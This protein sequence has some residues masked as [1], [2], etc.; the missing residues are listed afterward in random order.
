MNL[1]DIIQALGVII[2]GFF[3]YNQYTKNKLTDLKVEQLKHI[4][5]VRSKKRLDNS[6]RTYEELWN[7]LYV[8]KCDRIY[9]IQPHPLGNEDMLSI[10]F[11]VKRRS[12]EG[13]K[14]E[15]QNKKISE[16]AKFAGLL[17]RENFMYITDIEKQVE[18]RYAQHIF[19]LLDSKNIVIKK[20][21]DNKYDW[22]GTIVC[23]FQSDMKTPESET[24][25]IMHQVATNIQYI[26][27]EID[28][29]ED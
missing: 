24:K 14:G 10:Y 2:L 11:E 7:T 9:I 20:L 23:E 15:I 8:L 29:R 5:K 26:L 18:D 25:H 16:V 21:F 27:P 17:A 1:A 22:V 28:E 12:V 19:G 4:D 3:T 13:M 6:M